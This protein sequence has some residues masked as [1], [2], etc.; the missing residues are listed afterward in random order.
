MNKAFWDKLPAGIRT[1]LEGAMRDATTFANS[2]AG[3]ENTKALERIRASGRLTVYAPGPQELQP[4]RTAM[5]PV[6]QA[7]SGW[8][9][10]ATLAAMRQAMGA[11][12]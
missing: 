7:S 4:W 1:T 12:P 11:P 9:R 3:A 8:I 2:I 10:P 6:Y 5:N